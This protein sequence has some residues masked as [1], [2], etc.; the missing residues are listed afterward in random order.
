[1]PDNVLVPDVPDDDTVIKEAEVG[2]NLGMKI[3]SM[4]IVAAIFV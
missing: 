3:S 1:V 2:A 4:A